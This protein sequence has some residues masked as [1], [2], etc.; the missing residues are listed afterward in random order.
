MAEGNTP[1]VKNA[2]GEWEK[3]NLHHVGRQQGKLIEVLRSQNVYTRTGGPLHIPGPGSPV[4]SQ[5]FR[6]SY[7]QQRLRAAVNSGVVDQ[8]ILRQ[9]DPTLLR[10]AGL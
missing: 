4:R 1:F 10:R 7:W 2:L 8:S 6:I 3:I 5:A 9:V